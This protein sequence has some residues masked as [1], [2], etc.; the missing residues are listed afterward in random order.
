MIVISIQCSEYP[1][2]YC[3]PHGTS[4]KLVK[5]LLTNNIEEKDLTQEFINA[6]ILSFKTATIY[7][8]SVM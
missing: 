4:A 3:M 8:N 7:Y 5:P 2:I 6:I 1:A